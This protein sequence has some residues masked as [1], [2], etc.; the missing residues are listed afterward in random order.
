MVAV[1]LPLTTLILQHDAFETECIRSHSILTSQGKE[2]CDYLTPP[3]S[4]MRPVVLSFHV[5]TLDVVVEV[6]VTE[7][8]FFVWLGLMSSKPSCWMEVE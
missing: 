5:L 3:P 2:M 8:L 1:V 6:V 4:F 7:S